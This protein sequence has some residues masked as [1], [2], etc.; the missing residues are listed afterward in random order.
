MNHHHGMGGAPPP[1]NSM[2]QPSFFAGAPVTKVTILMSLLMYALI[3]MQHNASQLRK[4]FEMNSYQVWNNGQF[5]RFITGR[6]TF[7][8]GGDLVMGSIIFAMLSKRYEREMSS[9][10][11]ASFLLST[12]LV[13]IGIEYLLYQ[14]FVGMGF[15]GT[16]V[17]TTRQQHSNVTYT[18]P[19]PWV[20]ALAYL[21]HVYTPRQH[22][23]FFGILGFHFSEK[24]IPYAL[25]CQV[26]LM[27]NSGNI[28]QHQ[29]LP[30]LAGIMAGFACSTPQLPLANMEIP[31]YLTTPFKMIFGFL[32]D[33]DPPPILSA[34]VGGGGGG[35]GAGANRGGGA[36]RGAGGAGIPPA[37]RPPPQP[38]EPPSEVAIEQL[39]SMGFDR[40]RV[41]RALRQNNNNVEHAA[42]Q[43]LTG[44]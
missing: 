14:T 22:P 41:E 32:V 17:T 26:M 29:L 19:Y 21:F 16:T 30:S 12:W 2:N 35:A 23:R 5:Y 20:G 7:G 15:V 36:A 8:N 31:S 37:P 42:N 40:E 3:E 13:T 24:A 43:L 25:L 44:S 11:F 27:G 9:R 39:T 38:V 1:A 18:G 33:T 10:K 34:T 28:L 4:G 6:M